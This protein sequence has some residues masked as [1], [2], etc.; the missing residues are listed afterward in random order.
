MTT[1]ATPP[2]LATRTA[3]RRRMW[4]RRL[5]YCLPLAVALVA[6]EAALRTYVWCR[7]W[8]SNCYATQLF[9]FRPRD[10]VGCDLRPGFRLRSSHFEITIN[11][12][13]L[14]GPEIVRDKPP[15][16]RRLAIVGESS[17]FGYLV[18]D[19][20]VAARLLERNLRDRGLKVEVLNAGV[21]GYNL[22]QSTV[23]FREVIAPLKPDL[24]LTYLGWND[25]TYVVSETPAERRFRVRH[26]YVAIPAWE[27]LLGHSTL[28]GL[29]IYRI[30]KRPMQMTPAQIGGTQPTEAGAASF[31]ANLERLAD[32]VEAA[33]A[34]LVICAQ[35]TAAHPDVPAEL[36]AWLA[37]TPQKRVEIIELGAWL[38]DTER[39]FAAERQFPFFDA[40]AAIEPT[41]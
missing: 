9:L 22:N 32:D 1:N 8:T 21:P 17:T 37:D 6:G 27:R 28:C 24:V 40:R 29:V 33:G 39:D 38:H 31:R 25:L 5:K 23:R 10:D 14:R 15:G 16:V 26:D 18:R 30:W 7:G 41:T 2:P 35:A 19:G 11:S 34:R 12:L 36:G 3:G 13:G 4:L 20:E